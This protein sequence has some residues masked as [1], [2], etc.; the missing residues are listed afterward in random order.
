M[1]G[2]TFAGQAPSKVVAE[3]Y[4]I[5]EWPLLRKCGKVELPNKKT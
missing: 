5:S 4:S 2:L 1:R 3:D